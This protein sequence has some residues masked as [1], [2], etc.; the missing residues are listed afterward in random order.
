[1]G[2]TSTGVGDMPWVGEVSGG[3]LVF[4]GLCVPMYAPSNPVSPPV[5]AISTCVAFSD[6]LT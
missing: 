1:M 6:K 4:L 2:G 3:G 5:P